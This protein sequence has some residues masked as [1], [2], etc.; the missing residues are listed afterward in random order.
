MQFSRYFFRKFS[1]SSTVLIAFISLYFTLI[2]NYPFYQTVLKHHPFTGSVEDYFLFTIPFFVFFTLN[3]A[4]QLIA[5]P[6]LHKLIIPLLLVISAAISYQEIF[7]GIYFD[8][9]QLTNVLQTNFAESSRMITFPYLLWI[10]L[11]GVIPAWL[12]VRTQVNYRRWYK[13]ILMRM[14]MVAFSGMMVMLI[15]KFYYKDYAAFS[16]NHKEITH[17]ILP[18]NFIGSSIQLVK[19]HYKTDLPFSEIGLETLLVKPDAY[20]HVTILVVGETTRAQNWGLNGY[21]RQTTPHLAARD[22]IINFKHVSSCGTATAISVPCMFSR[23]TRADY[24]ETKAS[25]EDNLLDILQRSGIEVLWRD[26]DMGCKGVCERVPTQDMT[27]LNLAEYCKNGE[28]LDEILLKDLEA[29]LNKS[30][31]DTV[32]V[33]HTIGS[34]GPTYHERYSKPFEQF[35]PTC[36]TNEIQKCSNEQLVNTYDNG[37]LYIDNFLNNVIKLLEK[38]PNWESTMFYV[39]DHGESLGEDGIYLHA[40]P[41]AIAPVYQTRVPMVMWFSPTWVKNE[42]FDLACLRKNAETQEYTHDNY[43]HTVFSMMDTKNDE[44]VYYKKLDILAQ[45]KIPK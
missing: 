21:E 5:L 6:I 24:D 36:D 35:T 10:F 39:S 12:Y 4:F 18:S 42:G 30:D 34:H 17:L 23:Y 22:D 45:C 44:N 7:F 33:L 32:I 31:K 9:D 25:H 19:K 26:N 3:A 1:L 28:C 8:S 37:I 11:L 43:F 15:G 2:L 29:E 20:R 27:A 14:G 40:A 38:Q 16:R 41:Y 13:E